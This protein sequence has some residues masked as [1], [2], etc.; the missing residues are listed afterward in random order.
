MVRD[1]RHFYL[2]EKCDEIAENLNVAILERNKF[3]IPFFSLEMGDLSIILCS[4]I[5]R[6]EPN[7]QT[8]LN[9]SR[10]V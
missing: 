9:H 1:K 3:Y 6:N 10:N 2:Y 8:C 7:I 4:F 5:I